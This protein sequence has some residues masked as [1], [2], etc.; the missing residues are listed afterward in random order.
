MDLEEKI[1]MVR[2][3]EL[4]LAFVAAQ[5]CREQDDVRGVPAVGGAPRTRRRARRRG[6]RS[7]RAA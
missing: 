5:A 6:V 4:R 2:A 1:A 7:H 3:V